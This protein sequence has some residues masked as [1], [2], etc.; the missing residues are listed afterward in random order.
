MDF[1]KTLVCIHVPSGEIYWR[2]EVSV[3]A[4]R[5]MYNGRPERENETDLENGNL[6]KNNNKTESMGVL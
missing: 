4:L 2:V 5:K 6:K 1:T 3:A